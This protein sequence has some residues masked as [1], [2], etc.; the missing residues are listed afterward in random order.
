MKKYGKKGM[1]GKWKSRWMNGRVKPVKE[2]E[3]VDEKECKSKG[4]VEE[5]VDGW[6][7]ETS[8]AK[9]YGGD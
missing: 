6:E 1:G 3:S 2:T 8:E 4:K 5:K 9:I 7:N